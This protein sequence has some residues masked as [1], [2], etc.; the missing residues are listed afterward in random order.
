MK[1]I[2]FLIL[3]LLLVL[4]ELPAQTKMVFPNVEGYKTLKC[5]FHIHTLFSDGRVW[6]TVRVQEAARE[7]L[8]AIAITDHIESRK[9]VKQGLIVGDRNQAYKLAKAVSKSNNVIVIGGGEISRKMPPGHWNAIFVKDA[10]KLNKPN[11]EEVLKEAKEQ[12]AFIFWNHPGWWKQQPIEPKWEKM[13]EEMYQ[14]GYMM[15][16]ELTSGDGRNYFPE[17]HKWAI[18]KNLTLIGNSDMHAPAAF[19]IDFDS[20]KHRL[21]TLV[22]AKERNEESIKEALMER[23]TAVYVDNR[24]YG[25][26][27]WLSPFLNSILKVTKVRRSSNNVL[28]VVVENRSSA[29]IALFKDDK[30]CPIYFKHHLLFKP[31]QKSSFTIREIKRGS[32]D[33][34]GKVTINFKALDFFVDVDENLTFPMEIEI[35]PKK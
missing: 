16:I 28:S 27:E 22:F 21:V 13:H 35:P 34:G 24:I 8:D 29:P 17:V 9:Y 32:F 19:A 23:R 1:K 11:F 18:E 5:D 20:K 15:G 12:G 33:K 30:E 7:G 25:R 10:E 14:K 4:T 31:L 2:L 26:E 6:P 3:A